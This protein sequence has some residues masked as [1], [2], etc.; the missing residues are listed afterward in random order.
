MTSTNKGTGFLRAVHW[1]L[2]WLLAWLIAAVLLDYTADG[3]VYLDT[4]KYHVLDVEQVST[5]IYQ[6]ADHRNGYS[7]QYDADWTKGFAFNLDLRILYNLFFFD[8]RVETFGT[9]SQLREAGMWWRT[10]FNL[11]EWLQLYY[12]HHS[13]HLFDTENVDGKKFVL[14]NYYGVRLIF[15]N[16]KD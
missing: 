13:D 6:I 9:E 5:D 3:A 8:T 1:T 16:K 4:A 11:A 10:G 14:E 7:S 15:F 2:V 12:Q